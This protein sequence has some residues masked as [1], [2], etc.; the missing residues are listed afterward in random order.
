MPMKFIRT[1]CMSSNAQS[2]CI[3]TH[4]LVLLM[5]THC[6]S[7]VYICVALI[8]MKSLGVLLHRGRSIVEASIIIYNE[9]SMH[10]EW[11]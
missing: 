6:N 4:M 7:W 8:S 2:R 3:L 11:Y 10:F 9:A 5:C 1:N